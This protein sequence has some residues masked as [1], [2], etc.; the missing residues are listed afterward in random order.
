M[1]KTKIL[2][3][4]LIMVMLPLSNVRVSAEP[5]DMPLETGIVDSSNNQDNPHKT[6]T[7]IPKVS[8]EVYTLY[9]N[10]PCDGYVLRLLD[11]N[12][13]EAYSTVIPVGAT[14]LILPPYLFGIYELQLIP[15][16]C[17]YYFYGTI[18]L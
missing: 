10:T 2:I 12:D 7:I 13:N 3:M 11:E 17:N 6:P 18:D 15:N 16:N 9:F 14:S 1:K 4:T 8:I 5:A